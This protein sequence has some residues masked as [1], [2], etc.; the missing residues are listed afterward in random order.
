MNAVLSTAP[1]RN[2]L[3]WLLKEPD[4]LE[5]E[6]VVGLVFSLQDICSL[7]IGSLHCVLG[8]A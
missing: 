7:L 3:L 6:T 8:G 4:W 5:R 2:W 1:L